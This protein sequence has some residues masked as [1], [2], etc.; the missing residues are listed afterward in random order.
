MTQRRSLP[1]RLILQGLGGALITLPMLELTHGDAFAQSAGVAKR[2]I[3]FFEHGGYISNAD[4]N[5]EKLSPTSNYQQTDG[6]KPAEDTEALKLGLQ[7]QP[8]AGLEEYLLL[9]RGIDNLACKHDSPY[10]GDHH[11][12]NAAALTHTK[13]IKYSDTDHR[14]Q[15]RSIDFE[16]AARLQLRNPVPFP[17]INLAANADNYTAPFF[18]EAN[19]RVDG[20]GSPKV[21]FDKLFANV[22]TSTTPTPDPAATRARALKKSVL[23]GTREGLIRFKTKMSAQDKLAVEAHLEHLRGIERQLSELPVVTA[24]C[25]KPA[26]GSSYGDTDW[27]N[28]TYFPKIAEA[29][30]DIIVAAFRCGLTN[31]ATYN[32]CDFHADWMNPPYEAGYNSGHSL[33]HGAGDVGAGGPEA[34]RFNDWL[35]TIVDNR[36]YRSKIARRIIEG[37]RGDPA[38]PSL[39]LLNDAVMLWTSE[40]SCGVRHSVSDLPVMLA[41]RGGGLK[42]GR[43]LNFNLR[44]V[45]NP[46]TRDYATQSTL[47]NLFASIL[48]LFGY[49]DQSF[50]GTYGDYMEGSKVITKSV[51]GGLP[52]LV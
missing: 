32:M 35:K 19:Q 31:V 40:F 43:H 36:Q 46:G 4:K 50:G 23:D 3:L 25:T 12:A 16:L 6:W 39:N 24:S 21:A 44:A 2:F 30:A 10:N 18:R 15:G 1:R 49:P 20:E 45:G 27:F 11:W 51:S 52:G 8:L 17:S 41:G 28:G 13:V 33:H 26:V 34:Y 7:H 14:A 29:H 9:L 48:Q 37:L 5:G 47:S 42:T 38:T 22:T